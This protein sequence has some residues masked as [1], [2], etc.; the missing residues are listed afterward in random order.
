MRKDRNIKEKDHDPY[1]PK[2]KYPEGTYCPECTAQYEGGRWIWAGKPSLSGEPHLCPACRRTRDNFPAGEVFLSGAYLSAHRE[3]I[4]NLI[5]NIV[6]DERERTPLKRMI[7]LKE[8]LDGLRVSFTDDHMA[9]HIG[10][11]VNRAYHGA[12]E[13]KYSEAAKFV[14]L[15]WRREA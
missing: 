4:V 14:R 12:L 8:E 1:D 2:R 6:N 11:A 10:D 9:R 3:E 5:R 13:V 7:E 15:S